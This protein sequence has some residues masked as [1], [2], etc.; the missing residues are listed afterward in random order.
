M[1]IEHALEAAEN[2]AVARCEDEEV[3]KS[4]FGFG[5]FFLNDGPGTK[6]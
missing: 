6:P 2:Y 5:S 1:S 4:R 3:G